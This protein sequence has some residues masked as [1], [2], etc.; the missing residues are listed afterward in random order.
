MDIDIA[1]LDL[2]RQSPTNIYWERIGIHHQHGINTPLFSLYTPNSAGIGE[3]LDL[4][5]LI[6]QCQNLGYEIIQLL[7]LNDTGTDPSPYNA[8]SS[9]ALHPINLSLHALPNIDAYPE[10][11]QDLKEMQKLNELPRVDYHQV[12]QKKERFLQIYFQKEGKNWISTEKYKNFIIEQPWLPKYAL[13][14]TL[15]EHFQNVDWRQWP[16]EYI[17]QSPDHF[18]SLY[19][20]YQES[21]D[22]YSLLQYFCFQQLNQVKTYAENH[23]IFLKGD[24]PILIS[25]DSADTWRDRK[26]VV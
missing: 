10:L 18:Q 25:P 16:L 23:G 11:V 21:I 15:K 22:Y 19:D 14:K 13:F 1:T 4:I 20:R 8:Q 7:P 5:P 9:C 6:D 17:P 2:L 24:I 26:S 12:R 3:Y